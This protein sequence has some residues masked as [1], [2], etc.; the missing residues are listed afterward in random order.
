V[1]TWWRWARHDE[2][3]A[4]FRGA[5]GRWEPQPGAEHPFLAHPLTGLGLAHLAAGRPADALPPL[6][7]AALAG[8]A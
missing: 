7:R 4:A 3:I 1:S 2:A 5:L 8:G 6:E